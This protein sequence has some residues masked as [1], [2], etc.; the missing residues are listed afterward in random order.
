MKSS[1]VYYWGFKKKHLHSIAGSQSSNCDPNVQ[2]LMT[3]SKTKNNIWRVFLTFDQYIVSKKGIH[4]CLLLLRKSRIWVM[5]YYL[6]DCCVEGF[7]REFA[8]KNGSYAQVMVPTTYPNDPKMWFALK[9]K[10][11]FMFHP[12][13]SKKRSQKVGGLHFGS[14]YLKEVND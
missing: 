13:L 2:Y 5:W 14:K 9:G 1:P 8:K 4:Q 7:K 11:S 12:F 6:Q 10:P 3:C